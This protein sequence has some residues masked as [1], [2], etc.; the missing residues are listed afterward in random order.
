MQV[1]LSVKNAVF[2]PGDRLPPRRLYVILKG[3]AIYHGKTL[4]RGDSFG[5]QDVILRG[6]KGKTRLQAYA[7]T[8]LHVQVRTSP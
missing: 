3:S 5:E 6:K 1:A 2:A 4:G 8:F 7:V